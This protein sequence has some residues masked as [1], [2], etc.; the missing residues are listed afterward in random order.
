MNNNSAPDLLDSYFQYEVPLNRDELDRQAVPTEVNDYVVTEIT[1]QAGDRTGWYQ[2]RIPVRDFTR[3]S[4]SIE[5]F[6]RIES[7]RLWMT[8]V[9]DP[10]TVRLASLELVGSQWRKGDT[11]PLFEDD[12]QRSSTGDP[13]ISISSVNNEENSSVYIPP[14]GTVIAETRLAN[15]QRQASREQAMALRVKDLEPGQQLAIFKPFT[16]GIDLLKYSNLRMFAHAHGSMADGSILE[17]LPKEEGRTKARFF[18][19]LG[20]N[21]TDDYYEYEQPLTPSA[22]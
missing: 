7:M 18:I 6:R 21:E 20:A 19:R 16:Q 17:N 8:G 2:I 5:D 10:I 1:S 4:G 14:R 13:S 3:K 22:E 9:S 12:P 15:G 11:I